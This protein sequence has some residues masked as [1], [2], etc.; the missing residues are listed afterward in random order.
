MSS[1]LNL[2]HEGSNNLKD[3]IFFYRTCLK[4]HF[5]MHTIDNSHDNEN[6]LPILPLQVY[7]WWT[8]KWIFFKLFFPRFTRDFLILRW[9]FLGFFFLLT[10]LFLLGLG[11]GSCH[12]RFYLFTMP[13]VMVSYWL[14]LGFG[15]LVLVFLNPKWDFNFGGKKVDFHSW[16]SRINS[17]K[18]DGLWSTMGFCLNIP[19]LP[20]Q[21]ILDAY[22]VSLGRQNKWLI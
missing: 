11:V 17:H 6:A 13:F 21:L 14:Y 2:F 12:L 19:Y 15:N 18:W 10:F 16:S 8:K 5:S 4:D 22:Y 3:K 1:L 9:P 7:I 20:S